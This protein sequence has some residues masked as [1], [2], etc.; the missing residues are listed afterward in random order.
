[1]MIYILGICCLVY[2]I[3]LREN[4]NYMDY[5]WIWNVMGIVLILIAFID[6]YINQGLRM[7]SS[8]VCFMLLAVLVVIVVLIY[9]KGADT[10]TGTEKTIL[11]LAGGFDKTGHLSS[12]T[13]KRLEKALEIVNDRDETIFV[14]SG[15]LAYNEQTEAVCMSKYLVEHGVREEQIIL[16]EHSMDTGENLQN[17]YMLIK[18]AESL[19]I[20][21]SR[22]HLWRI[23]CLAKTQEYPEFNCAGADVEWLLQPHYYVRE[24]CAMFREVLLGRL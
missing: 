20:V 12:A 10:G 13:K 15:G 6:S 3:Y 2:Y 22:F 18:D 11:V 1:M 7:F 16:D 24:I 8:V 5:K 9:E 4:I 21:S 19:L 14:L 17:S 23:Q